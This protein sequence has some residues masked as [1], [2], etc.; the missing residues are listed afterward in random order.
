[1]GRTRHQVH[2]VFVFRQDL[3]HGLNYVFDALIRREQ[4]EGE[5]HRFPFDAETVLIEIGIEKGQ[6]GNA[7][8][9]HVDLA[10]R[11]LED[12]LQELGRKLAHDNEAVG[13]LSDLFHDAELVGAGLAQ[14]GV[15]RGHHRHLQS[16]QQMQDM[17]SGRAAENSI[18]VLQ[19]DHVDIVEV[20][21]FRGL[22]IRGHVILRQRPS[23][24][25]GIV[26]SLF[27]IVHRQRQQPGRAIFSRDGLAQVGGEGGD[28]TM[29][30][31]IIA[32]HRDST[33]HRRLGMPSRTDGRGL[34]P[35]RWAGRDDFQ[36]P[37][38]KYC[39]RQ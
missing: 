23:H 16:A 24:S 28:S 25:C 37:S 5:Q 26:I 33:G 19:A 8:R 35:R 7:V 9:D 22:L 1:M 21:E 34:I 30:R 18:L 38:G 20:Q 14:N 13:K 10:A 31:K 11:H 32:N 3:R 2:H 27:R 39:L 15:Q 12:F 36:H 6:V 4:S 17:A 29:T